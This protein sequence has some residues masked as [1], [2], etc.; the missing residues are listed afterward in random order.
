MKGVKKLHTEQ[1]SVIM[2]TVLAGAGAVFGYI[3][4]EYTVLLQVLTFMACADFATGIMANWGNLSSKHGYRGIAKKLMMFVFVATGHFV[5]KVFGDGSMVQDA[6]TMFYIG[7]EL[8]SLVENGGKM[9]LPVPNV[10]LRA[11][12]IFKDKAGEDKK[13]EL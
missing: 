9:G 10:L 11:V 8:I 4:G 7:N 6:V 1:L 5:D 3:F 2:K 13:E 12:E